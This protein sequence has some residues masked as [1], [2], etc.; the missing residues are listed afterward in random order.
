MLDSEDF[1]YEFF[2]SLF[3]INCACEISTQ[4]KKKIWIFFFFNFLEQFPH[5]YIDH[6]TSRKSA[7]KP[8]LFFNYRW[9]LFLQNFV[10]QIVKKIT[11]GDSL[12]LWLDYILRTSGKCRSELLWPFR[13]LLLSGS[14]VDTWLLPSDLA[15]SPHFPLLFE[16][17]VIHA[18]MI[19]FFFWEMSK[20][21]L[22]KEKITVTSVFPQ[23]SVSLVNGLESFF[24]VC[25]GSVCVC[26][27]KYVG[28]S[29]HWHY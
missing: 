13:H 5:G 25:L 11:I 19:F 22:Q 6:C 2:R 27:C 15:G 18:S 24:Y 1:C 21:E 16:S 10:W 8:L 12:C 20:W 28:F 14:A 3:S 9:F 4:L 26:V 29:W 23:L 7:G 17:W